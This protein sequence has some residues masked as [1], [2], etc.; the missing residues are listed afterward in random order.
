MKLYVLII[1]LFC[2]GF[3]TPA[4][5]KPFLND[6][7]VNGF[8]SGSYNYNFNNPPDNKIRFRVFDYDNNSFKI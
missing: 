8:F 6:I 2:A 4:Q 3:Q 1:F 5:D 7:K